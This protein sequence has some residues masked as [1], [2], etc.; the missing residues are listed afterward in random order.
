MDLKA[1]RQAGRLLVQ[2][3]HVEPGAPGETTGELEQE[4]NR[5]AGCQGYILPGDGEAREA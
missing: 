3:V 2:A 5:M 1:D 4:L